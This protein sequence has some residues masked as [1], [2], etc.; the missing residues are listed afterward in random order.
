MLTFF[1]SFPL[2]LPHFGV[3]FHQLVLPAQGEVVVLVSSILLSFSCHYGIASD[4]NSRSIP[5]FSSWVVL[6]YIT[7]L[8]FLFLLCGSGNTCT[9][10]QGH[11]KKQIMATEILFFRP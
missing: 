7:K 3:I 11:M 5:L 1:V 6:S 9:H 4:L 8:I 2:P 10:T